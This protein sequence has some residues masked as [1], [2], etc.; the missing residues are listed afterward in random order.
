MSIDWITVG[1]QIAN[2]LVLVWLLKTLLYRPILDGIDAREAEITARMD[3][4]L[5][6][7]AQAETVEQTFRDQTRALHLAQDEMSE[8]IRQQAE[9]QRDILL[10]DT[11]ARLEQERI[12]WQAHLDEQARSYIAKLHGAGADAVLAMTRKALLDLSDE[13][14]EARMAQHLMAKL[15]PMVEDLR[16]STK[17]ATTAVITSHAALPTAAQTDMTEALHDLLPDIGTRFAVDSDQTPGLIVQIGGAQV[18]WTV[19][20]YID[21][22]EQAIKAQFATSRDAKGASV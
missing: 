20:S 4:A 6:A 16:R 19:A 17:G 14:L 13:T 2:F 9:A 1:A 5:Q 21:G 8:T 22:L 12:A 7:K 3:Q 18:E 10:S 15:Q 11:K